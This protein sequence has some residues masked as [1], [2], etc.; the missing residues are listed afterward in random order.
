[1]E[2]NK[3]IFCVAIFFISGCS[4]NDSSPSRVISEDEITKYIESIH[5]AFVSRDTKDIESSI[6]Y[7]DNIIKKEGESKILSIYY[8]KAR[9][10]YLQEKY[11][12]ALETISLT[13]RN[14]YDIQKEALYIVTGDIQKG[15]TLLNNLS[16]YYFEY[17]REQDKDNV[18]KDN[19]V[20]ALKIIY[21]LSNKDVN[22]LAD[23]LI[24]ENIL[25]EE[26][27]DSLRRNIFS[28]QDII[29]SMWPR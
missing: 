27:F 20:F 7:I 22:E 9:L 18:E 26:K 21:M 29:D 3:I 25:T 6:K 2:M 12:D 15:E 28:K 23:Q 5:K 8:D 1:M 11:N 17:L 13:S 19:I 16:T 24:Q 10:L 4:N 14:V